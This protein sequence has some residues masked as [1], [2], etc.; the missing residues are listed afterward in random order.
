[1][2]PSPDNVPVLGLV[3]PKIRVTVGINFPADGWFI[4]FFPDG[5][6]WMFPFH[7]LPFT[8][9]LVMVD[10]C[11]VTSDDSVQEGVTFFIIAI[12]IL[13]ADV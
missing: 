10:P 4:N 7:N 2:N 12:Q 5:R 9:W 6:L 1:L 13:L 8:L 11:F 3:I